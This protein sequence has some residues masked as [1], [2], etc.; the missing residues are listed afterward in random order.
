[1]VFLFNRRSPAVVFTYSI[2]L[3][4]PQFPHTTVMFADIAGFTAWSSAREPAQVFTLLESVYRAFDK[5]AKQ[6]KVYKVETV[7]DCYVA[8]C[9]L[10][11]PRKD[12]AIIMA[13]FARDCLFKMNE[14]TKKLE[15][16]L[17]PDTGD[18]ALR[19]GLHSGPVT[20]GVLRGD[21]ARFQLFGDTMNTAARVES[22]GKPNRIH[23]SEETA[24]LLKQSGKGHWAQLREGEFVAG[25]VHVYESTILLINRFSL[26]LDKVV[27]KGKGELTT[28]WLQLKGDN[29]KS[30]HS[31]GTSESGASAAD[32]A[33]VRQVAASIL[34]PAT[35][36]AKEKRLVDWNIDLL[37]RLLKQIIARRQAMKTKV[38]DDDAL[39]KME[40]KHDEAAGQPIDEVE[41]DFIELPKFR[42][43][44][45]AVL[46]NIELPKEV[47][48][49][50]NEFVSVIASMYR[51]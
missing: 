18:L 39:R 15:S 22:S 46:Q 24:E 1:M 23:C 51:K 29:A 40:E 33:E 12:H 48:Q 47:E 3:L 13:R 14:M 41:E 34:Q 44:S 4:S 16:M 43:T 42:E 7:G 27:A 38:E 30:S 6:R 49:Q 8:V 2:L 28:Y 21:N 32:V 10:P 26:S 35:D 11:D 50:L 31:A 36:Q 5:I 25:I 45:E 20:A 17:G 19:I 9:G 37:S